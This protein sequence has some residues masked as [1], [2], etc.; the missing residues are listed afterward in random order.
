MGSAFIRFEDL[1]KSFGPKRVLRGVHLEVREGETM[2]ILGG[3][4]SGKS[5]LLRHA[6]G[7]FVPDRG[8]VVIDGTDLSGLSEEELVPVR[9]KLGMLFQGGALFDSMDVF[10]NVA[11]ALREHTDCSEEE[12]A[13]R[14]R[15]KLDLVELD[16]SVEELMPSDLSGGMRKRVALARSIALEPR[17][18]LYDEPTTGLDPITAHAINVM[19]RNLQ[20]TLNVTSVVV[21]H[22]ISSAYAVGDRIAFLHE[23]EMI[24]VGSVEQARRSTDPNL[25]AFLSAGNGGGIA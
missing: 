19:V 3:S 18:I 13:S 6:V 9:K 21:T 5:V 23:G 15:E 2:V 12:I 4:G 25:R 11:Y 7:L 16:S 20:R 1:H 14:V 10:E 8:R 22:D 24:F 17:G